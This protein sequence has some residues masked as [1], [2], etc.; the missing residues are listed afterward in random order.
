MPE[1]T[2]HLRR[3]D[4]SASRPRMEASYGVEPVDAAGMLAWSAVRD[5]LTNARNYWGATTRPDGR[6]HVMPVW[7]LWLDETFCFST[8]VQSR[9]G[10]NLAAHANAVAHLE[11][12]DDVVI[13]EGSVEVV[14]GPAAL[15]RFADAYD[16][17]YHFRPDVSSPAARVYRL[18]PA[19]AFAWGE[20]DF[21]KSATRWSFG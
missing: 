15:G 2:K 18:R 7:G 6:P 16:A 11:S 17:K 12:G 21:T 3:R 5:R 9:K 10:R 1:P 19:V 4:P 14:T 8:D 20:K 13:V